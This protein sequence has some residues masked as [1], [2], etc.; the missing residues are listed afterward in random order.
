MPSL[1]ASSPALPG[2]AAGL[3]PVASNQLPSVTGGAA[4]GFAALVA[5]PDAGQGPV[6][7]APQPPAQAGL[8]GPRL[9]LP[10]G[11]PAPDIVTYADTVPAAAPGTALPDMRQDIAA[12]TPAPLP[13]SP[14]QDIAPVPAEP[15]APPPSLPVQE[16][17]MGEC[18]I[19]SWDFHGA[20]VR[21]LA[22]GTL[23]PAAKPAPAAAG[24]APAALPPIPADSQP[25]APDM[26]TPADDRQDTVAQATVPVPGDPPLPPV[27]TP[28]D[29]SRPP[30]PATPEPIAADDTAAPR[31]AP[32]G[33]APLP[34]PMPVAAGATTPGPE[35]ISLSP[36]PQ[37]QAEGQ[38]L[39]PASPPPAAT[40]RPMPQDFRLPPDI[41]REVAAAVRAVIHDSNS[42][43]D[44]P[45]ASIDATDSIASTPSIAAAPLVAPLHR[46]FVATNRPAI[47]TSRAEWMQA[48]IERI[49]E[50]PQVDGKREAQITLRPDALGAVEV[51]IEQR[52]DRLHVTMNADSP[53]ARQLL[54]ESAPRLQELA[55]AR[56][57]R[58]SQA[59]VGGGESHDRRPQPERQ[60]P[61][62]PQAP[63]PASAATESPQDIAGDLIA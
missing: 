19:E 20:S 14:A 6:P 49:A 39:P 59:G 28:I 45:G 41:A 42:D 57:L 40:P 7:G 52:Q 56:G 10:E 9:A 32:I 62:M 17:Q 21:A 11:L 44:E 48:M 16:P 63:R 55:E 5:L 61:A 25:S 2:L 1:N 37:D 15:A 26:E 3:F 24:K 27:F 8:P 35:A 4:G 18:R 46:D 50:M 23:Q 54:T 36:A 60:D 53:Q 43:S 31:L 13:D 29:W 47:D 38:A 22:R 30:A 51:R 33:V 34:A 58:L 12:S